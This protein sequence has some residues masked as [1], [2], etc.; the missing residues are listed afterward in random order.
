MNL[1]R[2]TLQLTH[3]HPRICL[4]PST[5]RVPVYAT[6][7]RGGIGQQITGQKPGIITR[8]FHSYNY[9]AAISSNR[10]AV[11]DRNGTTVS[12]Y[13]NSS[14]SSNHSNSISDGSNNHPAKA[15]SEIGGSP[16]PK[17]KPKRESSPIQVWPFLAILIG[18]TLLFK[19][20]LKSRTGTQPPRE[21]AQIA[22]GPLT[23][24][25]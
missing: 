6:C 21:G 19:Q 13:S 18:G 10:P 17:S 14:N 3:R 16:R 23:I 5:A 7:A 11:S 22:S 8:N 25:K 4:Q 12:N 9:K 15:R 1:Q 20:L 24:A 2:R